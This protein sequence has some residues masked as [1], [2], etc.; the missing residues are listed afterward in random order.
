MNENSP[1]L[2]TS[3]QPS[4]GRQNVSLKNFALGKFLLL[5]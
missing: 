1:G 3:S 5:E 4:F 2:S